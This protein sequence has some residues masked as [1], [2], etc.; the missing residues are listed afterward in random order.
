MHKKFLSYAFTLLIACAVLPMANAQDNP[1]KT[2]SAPAAST[3]AQKPHVDAYHLDFSLNELQNEKKINSRHYSM[4]VSN[5]SSP[6][7]LKIGTRVPVDGE[8]GKFDYLD[9]GTSITAQMVSWQTPLGIDIYVDVSNFAN[10]DEVLHGN[11]KP[12][13]RQM[14][15]NGRMPVVLGKPM[16]VGSV[17]DPNSD[18]EFQLEV[19]INKL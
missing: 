14:R 7:T 18:H 1:D 17:D 2:G 16:V 15:I 9:V 3:P 12:L 13:L 8:N 6:K 4:N 11:G 19:T 10:P 5:D